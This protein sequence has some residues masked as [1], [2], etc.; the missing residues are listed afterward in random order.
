MTRVPN[1]EALSQR[2]PFW[3]TPPHKR[4]IHHR[5]MPRCRR[6]ALVDEPPEHKTRPKRLEIM[7][8]YRI[9]RCTPRIGQVLLARSS[10]NADPL[11]P[12]RSLHRTVLRETRAQY[13]RYPHQLFL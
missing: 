1:P 11:A 5:H 9:Q 12:V 3:E 10:R 7:R 2:I 4:L 13:P 6:I 8:A